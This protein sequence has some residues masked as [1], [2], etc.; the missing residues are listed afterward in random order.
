MINI[1][2]HSPAGGLCKMSTQGDNNG[3][4]P[5]PLRTEDHQLLKGSRYYVAPGRTDNEK[6]RVIEAKV[7]IKVC[8]SQI[9][10]LKLLNIC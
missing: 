3:L 4:L 8:I 7:A 9:P 5:A 6:R 10:H 2:P 1:V